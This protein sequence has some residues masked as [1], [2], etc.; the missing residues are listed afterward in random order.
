M[1]TGY[2]LNEDIRQSY[3]SSGTVYLY[4]MFHGYVHVENDG[5]GMEYDTIWSRAEEENQAQ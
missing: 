3:E 4:D 1:A 5:S 2:V